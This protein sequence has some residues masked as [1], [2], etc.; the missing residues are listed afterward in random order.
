MLGEDLRTLIG[1]TDV[2]Q[3]ARDFIQMEDEN[4]RWIS[5]MDAFEHMGLTWEDVHQVED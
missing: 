2:D 3:R 1:E 5:S 4:L